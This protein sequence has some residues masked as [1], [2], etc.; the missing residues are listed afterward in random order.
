MGTI[1]SVRGDNPIYPWRQFYLFVQTIIFVQLQRSNHSP[2]VADFL[3]LLQ[4]VG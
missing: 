1:L 2:V 4:M 3:L